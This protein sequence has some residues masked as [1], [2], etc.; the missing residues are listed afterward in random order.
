MLTI[1]F[2]ASPPLLLTP[3]SMFAVHNIVTHPPGVN[4]GP[5]IHGK[6]DFEV[7][8]LEPWS[9]S[10]PDIIRQLTPPTVIDAPRKEDIPDPEYHVS[11]V[12]YDT[13]FKMGQLI[14]MNVPLS[15]SSFFYQF[16]VR[17]FTIFS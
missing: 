14:R 5:V 3:G 10:T 7:I 8:G 6:G 12:P 16:F 15:K 13:G 9:W 4:A 17:F 2:C 11:P 1:V